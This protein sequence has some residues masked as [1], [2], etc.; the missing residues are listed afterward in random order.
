MEI[1]SQ[2]VKV[3]MDMLHPLAEH[4]GPIISV[5]VAIFCL[6]FVRDFLI[7]QLQTLEFY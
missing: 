2:R 6:N 4:N 3:N 7:F 1:L 5:N